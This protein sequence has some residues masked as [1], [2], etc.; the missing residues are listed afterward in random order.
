MINRPHFFSSVRASLFNGKLDVGQ[1]EGMSAIL[2]EW[3][4][5]FNKDCRQL[6]YM[7][8]T[9]YHECNKTMQ[10][11]TEYGKPA[12]FDKYDAGTKLGKMLGNTV[13]GDGEKYKGRGFVQLTGR[14]NYQK[15]GNKL[16]I[17]LINF[18]EKAL[19]LPISTKILFTGMAEGWFTGRKFSQYF[20]AQT[21][22]YL[23]A[24]KIINGLDCYEKIAGYAR[25]F[26]RA[27]GP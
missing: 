14:S 23:N 12:Y 16:G 20:N 21:G 22:D 1:V 11:I 5:G 18:P 25:H 2:D 17:D 10:P 4:K 3:D 6:A 13:K 7:L 8:A 9:V 27:L 19:E 24:R 15:A 26:H